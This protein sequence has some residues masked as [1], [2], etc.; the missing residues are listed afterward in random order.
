MGCSPSPT[1]QLVLGD[2]PNKLF[3]DQVKMRRH[4][5]QCLE[6]LLPFPM[7]RSRRALKKVG[8]FDVYCICRM[9][10]MVEGEK[11]GECTKCLRLYH[12]DKCLSI[13]QKFLEGDI[14]FA[15]T[16][17]LGNINFH[18]FLY[19]ALYFYPCM[20]L[21]TFHPFLYHAYYF[22]IL[23]CTVTVCLIHS[24]TTIVM[25][26]LICLHTATQYMGPNISGGH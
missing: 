2:D 22:L 7:K 13:S 10:E 21:L 23:A 9:L 24:L 19:H 11:W 17:Y 12:M 14:G 26:C 25:H 5:Y 8:S 3:F 1:L 20:H 6:K 15:L 18:L 4:L 16:V